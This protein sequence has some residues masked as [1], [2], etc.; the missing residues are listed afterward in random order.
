MAVYFW[1]NNDWQSRSLAAQVDNIFIAIDHEVQ[2]IADLHFLLRRKGQLQELASVFADYLVINCVG[3]LKMDLVVCSQRQLLNQVLACVV[4]LLLHGH[5][6]A[7]QYLFVGDE[8][9]SPL[10]VP[11]LLLYELN[12]A[13]VLVIA[14]QDHCIYV[15]SLG[16]YFSVFDHKSL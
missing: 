6:Q 5:I 13:H 9:G 1:K 8:Y 11:V 7:L 12:V 3:G 2:S 14:W 10:V 15:P 16:C 4:W